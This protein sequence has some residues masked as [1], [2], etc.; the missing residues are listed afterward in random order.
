MGIKNQVQLITYPDSL[1]GSLK[2]LKYVLD[3]YFPG[4]FTGGI[5][6]LP[7]FPSS[8]DRGFAPLTYSEIDP[9]FGTW[10]DIKQIGEKSPVLLDLM[11]NHISAR[12]VFFQDFLEKG[13][14]SKY[15]D[16]FIPLE[17]I[18]PDGIP[19]QADIDKIFL[20]RTVPYSEFTIKQ[21]GEIEK[22]WT[23]FGK[24]TPSEQIDLDIH[25]PVTRELL[26]NFLEN[27]SKNNVEMV[28][29]DAV[30]YVI[31][32]SGTTC[33]FV[34]PEIYDFLDWISVLAHS[35]NIELLPEIHS[36]YEFQMKLVEK[37]YWIYDFILPYTILDV[38]VNKTFT[39]LKEYLKDRPQKQFTMLDCHDGVPLKPDLNGLYR[40]EDAQKV[41]DAC[42]SRGGNLSY[43]ISPMHQ[44]PDGLKVHQIRGTYYSLLDC[45][46]TAY[47]AAR[48]IQFF[49][50]GI[51]QVYYVGVLAGKNDAEAFKRTGEGREINRH[52]YTLEEIDKEAKKDVVQKLFELIRLRNTHPA[53]NGIFSVGAS[54]DNELILS[55]KNGDLYTRLVVENH[56]LSATIFYNEEDSQEIKTIVL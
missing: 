22:V 45:N 10:D 38:F 30:G 52:N 3:K 32:K 37:N 48:A 44:D 15:Y 50:P 25:S 42:L 16:L 14:D 5:H 1:G 20:R 33:F 19:V 12:S 17:K 11:V 13:R 55:W 29:L 51:P 23:S 7:P 31:K 18:W 9:N 34:E 46:D 47:L 35:L 2:S 26:S 36:E 27:F 56:L 43:I 24:T 6:I 28:R 49:V 40:P 8:G 53:F 39:R 21:S 41:V 4:L 54:D